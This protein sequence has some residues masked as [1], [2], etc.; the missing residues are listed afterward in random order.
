[1]ISVVRV[2]G[3]LRKVIS[4]VVDSGTYKSILFRGHLQLDPIHL[5]VP[6]FFNDS[7]QFDPK[8]V[9]DMLFA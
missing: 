8:L 7:P 9:E 1:M 4:N 2:R 5:I 3:F 6:S